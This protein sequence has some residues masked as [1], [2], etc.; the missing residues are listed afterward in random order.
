MVPWVVSAVK[1]GA[2]S[3][4]RSDMSFVLFLEDHLDS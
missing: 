2:T 3:F 4:M 1:S